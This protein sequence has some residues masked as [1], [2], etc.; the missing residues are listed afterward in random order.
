LPG[1]SGPEPTANVVAEAWC[2]WRGGK[3]TVRFRQ[4]LYSLRV[5]VPPP[6]PP[7]G[8]LRLATNADAAVIRGW[9]ADFVREARGEHLGPEFFV[10]LIEARQVSLWDDGQPRCLAAAIKHTHQASAIGVLYTPAELRRRGYGTA[11]VAALSHLLFQ[12]GTKGCYL[13]AD[14]DNTAVSR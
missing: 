12:S 5:L 13:Y 4:R 9:S 1:V 11:T 10:A 7:F 6:R 2:R 3:A 8:T 14:P